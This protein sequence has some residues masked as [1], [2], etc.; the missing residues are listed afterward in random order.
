MKSPPQA[1]ICLFIPRLALLS[2]QWALGTAT[3]ITPLTLRPVIHKGTPLNIMKL[4]RTKRLDWENTCI[5][6][7]MKVRKK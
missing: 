4:L 1:D 6:K 7:M 3:V 2:G 5:N